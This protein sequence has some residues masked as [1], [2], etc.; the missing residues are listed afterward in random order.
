MSDSDVSASGKH[1]VWIPQPNC[2][3]DFIKGFVLEE[4][5]EKEESVLV[6]SENG[7]KTTVSTSSLEKVNPINFDKCDNM[8]SLTYLN[9]PSVLH[10]LRLRYQSDLI[11]TY[12]G[13]FLVSMNPYKELNIYN[14]DFISMYASKAGALKPHIFS[15][16][17]KALANL[18]IDR[19]DQSIL[20]TGES[21]AG[22]TE[23][24]KK[25]IQYIT[26]RTSTREETQFNFEQKILQATPILEAFGNAKTSRNNNSSR[27]GKFI[28]IDIDPSTQKLKGANIE[29]YL[30]EKSR[31]VQRD[32]TERN[33]HIFYQLLEGLQN[34]GGSLYLEGS[35]YADFNYLKGTCMKVDGIDDKKEFKHLQHA[36]KVMGFQDSDVVEIFKVVALILFLGNVEFTNPNRDSGAILSELSPCDQIAKLLGNSSAS[37][38]MDAFIRP[39][40]KAGMDY[41]TQHKTAAQAKFS[42]DALSKKLY[43]KLFKFIVD[44]INRNFGES[45]GFDNKFIG[46]LDIA[47][48]EIFEKNSFEQLCI[49]YTNEKLQQF[50]NHHMFVLEQS[51]Y[52]KENINWKF[53]DFGNDLVPT[54]NAIEQ[55]SRSNLGVLAI[56]DEECS[57]PKGTDKSLFEKLNANLENRKMRKKAIYRPNRARTGFIIKHY[58]GDVEYNVEGWLEK[59]R[60]PINDN[61][62]LALSSCGN[63]FVA[64]FFSEEA[65]FLQKAKSTNRTTLKTI[66][67]KH[68]DQLR[69][70]LDELSGT[71]PHFVRCILPNN[72]KRSDFFDNA[73][74]LDQ[75]RCNGVLE[76]IRIARS[77]YPN[78]IEFK[79]FFERYRI[80]GKSPLYG[81]NMKTNSELI[82]QQLSL[83]K[84]AFK[85]GLTKLFFR[86]GVLADLEKQRD[87][88]IECIVMRFQSLVRARLARREFQKSLSRHRALQVLLGNLKI[89]KSY[90]NDPWY[91]LCIQLRPFINV[92]QDPSHHK[93]LNEKL[94]SSEMEKKQ[95]QQQL[96]DLDGSKKTLELQ[97]TSLQAQLSSE[98]SLIKQKDSVVDEMKKRE[99]DLQSELD[100]KK[101]ECLKSK[102]EIEELEAMI[103]K[104]EKQ[105]KSLETELSDKQNALIEVEN[106]KQN[107]EADLNKTA[108]EANNSK[109]ESLQ[110]ALA[111]R[112]VSLQRLEKNQRREISSVQSKV[113]QLQHELKE[114]NDLLQAKISDEIKFDRGKQQYDKIVLNLKNQVATLTS[115]V[116]VERRSYLDL[117]KRM[118]SMEK[119]NESMSK[120]KKKLDVKLA[121]FALHSCKSDRFGQGEPKSAVDE[122]AAIKLELYES[123]AV[124][125]K[126]K[127]ENEKVHRELD[128]INRKLASEA[129]ENRQLRLELSKLKGEEQPKADVVPLQE[130]SQVINSQLSNS[131]LSPT[132]KS[133]NASTRQE[134]FRLT[135]MLN[136]ANTKLKRLQT[137]Q[138]SKAV[139]QEESTQTKLKV[140]LLEERVKDLQESTN[141][142][143]ER[144]NDYYSKLE[145][146][147]IAIKVSQRAEAASSSEVSELKHRLA[148][149]ESDSKENDVLVAQLNTRKRE[150]E[151]ELSDTKF[152]LKRLEAKY[153]QTVESQGRE[154]EFRAS[155]VSARKAQLEREVDALNL[156]VAERMSC[157]TDLKKKNKILTLQLESSQ[158]ECTSFVEARQQWQE[159][160]QS[161]KAAYRDCQSA[162]VNL[163]DQL[164]EANSKLDILAPQLAMLKA[165]NQNLLSEREGMMASKSQ[166][167]YKVQEISAAFD[168]CLAKLNLQEQDQ[169]DTIAKLSRSLESEKTQSEHLKQE[170]SKLRTAASEYKESFQTLKKEAAIAV[171]ESKVLSRLNS[172]MNEKL[173]Q[174]QLVFVKEKEAEK[175]HWAERVRVLEEKVLAKRDVEYNEEKDLE[176]LERLTKD[177][178]SRLEWQQRLTSK[179]E[180]ES[181]GLAGKLKSLKEEVYNM[182]KQ[183]SD[184]RIAFN[185]AERENE[186]Y[187]ERVVNLEKELLEWRRR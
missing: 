121:E 110:R 19:K 84:E 146:A 34:F 27:F 162:A 184:T 116:E 109:V 128:Q 171:E 148:F 178:E 28:K 38:L 133:E 71:H 154:S 163:E 92:K 118:E 15:I 8:A 59:N 70:L 123:T 14:S 73:L 87:S 78:R 47:G 180:A 43:E 142:Y 91:K 137:T 23:N 134:I 41:M 151:A 53:I 36:F 179:F 175:K 21:G 101:R 89:Y 52:L 143:K 102:G 98:A 64:S 119:E 80:L 2:P 181:S 60:D 3:G 37:N 160:S 104:L 12:S 48:F 129:F 65:E 131:Q 107:F 62:V 97:I 31:V 127:L 103:L 132:L 51:E 83:D 18:V 5:L 141:L 45:S 57:V 168:K 39:K 13:L 186:E 106:A 9:E 167:E 157:E 124:L 22:K 159:E 140:D 20:V 16:T 161:M 42:V 130:N 145:A 174:N 114:A 76:G 108:K 169:G 69:N 88:A 72:Q 156:E 176:T 126:V 50:F 77:G 173:K 68:K 177:L 122:Y 81:S 67:Q 82:L 182:Q 120:Q 49:N 95:Y 94:Q 74:I 35:R 29:W 100:A 112:E 183:E 158:R 85:V 17:E 6:E 155:N 125:T 170:I 115:D 30:L 96:V 58:A 187:K 113:K 136:Q 24:T 44:S 93:A 33:Y 139:H 32:Q 172:Q 166:L 153:H 138:E 152:S 135:S 117:L 165:T 66:A 56:L 4:E 105:V 26:H 185:R 54:I 86:N 111:E 11:Y 1:A 46:I 147:E 25:I 99:L 164:K 63:K 10:N 79:P 55:K 7:T 144:A 40:V 90:E 75:L 149:I 150:L 61:V